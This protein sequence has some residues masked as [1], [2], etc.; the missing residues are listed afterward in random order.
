MGADSDGGEVGGD[1]EAGPGAGRAGRGRGA[2]VIDPRWGLSARIERVEAVADPG[3]VPPALEELE[4]QL[5]AIARRHAY[6]DEVGEFRE[7]PLPEDDGAGAAQLPG[8]ERVLGRS[9]SAARDRTCRR[10]DS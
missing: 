5:R 3:Q 4:A 6:R 2:P 9:R 10:R 7:G 1:G 8:D